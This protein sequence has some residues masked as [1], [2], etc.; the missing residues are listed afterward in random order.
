MTGKQR[1]SPGG[2]ARPD[3]QAETSPNGQAETSPGR[4]RPS[5]ARAPT[6]TSRRVA[7]GQGDLPAHKGKQ[8]VCQGC[9][10]ITKSNTVLTA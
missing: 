9:M 1:P 5:P 7:S 4:Q 10:V 2:Q 3:G 6:R 8:P